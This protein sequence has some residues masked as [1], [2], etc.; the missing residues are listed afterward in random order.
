MKLDDTTITVLSTAIEIRGVTNAA[1]PHPHVVITQQLDRK[2]YLAVNKALEA[3]GGA[4]SRKAKAHVFTVDPTPAIEHA[5]LTGEIDT[6]RDLDFFPTPPPLAERL[7]AN[8]KVGDHVLEPSAGTGNLVAPC[9]ARG[10]HVTVCE[11]DPAMRGALARTFGA[12]IGVLDHDDFLDVDP[13]GAPPFDR[14]VMNPPFTKVGRGAGIDH[15]RHAAQMLRRD[16]GTLTAIL[17]AGVTFREDSRHR[18]FRAWLADLGGVIAPLP[19]GSFK[20]SGTDVRTVCVTL[21]RR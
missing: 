18:E 8:V 12:A 6:A 13:E 9:L 17:G 1:N 15:V 16:G 5:L 21:V 14:I 3:C 19:D 4:W 2:A 11:R 20:T 7:V 10:A